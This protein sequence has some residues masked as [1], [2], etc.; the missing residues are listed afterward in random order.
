MDRIKL[1][2][3]AISHG[4]FYVD[5]CIGVLAICGSTSPMPKDVSGVQ[6]GVVATSVKGKGTSSSLPASS[7]DQSLLAACFLNGP[8]ADDMY[9]RPAAGFQKTLDPFVP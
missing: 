4:P 9:V 5:F 7:V 3:F 6:E 8:Y 2:L 1:L